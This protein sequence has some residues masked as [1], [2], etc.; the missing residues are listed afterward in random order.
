MIK[1]YF[2]TKFKTVFLFCCLFLFGIQNINAQDVSDQVKAARRARI[3][4][5]EN[6]TEGIEDQVQQGF[7]QKTGISDADFND[8]RKYYSDTLRKDAK[9]LNI[10]LST[11]YNKLTDFQKREYIE[12]METHYVNMYNEFKQ[13]KSEFP[14]SIAEVV[15]QK[16]PKKNPLITCNPACDNVGFENGTLSAWTCGYSDCSSELKPACNNP[17]NGGPTSFSYS[18]PTFSPGVGTQ[19]AL[20]PATGSAAAGDY[21]DSIIALASGNDPVIASGGGTLPMVCPGYNYSCR[22][23]D[24][25]N[26]TSGFL[27]EPNSGV[28]FL[29]QEFTVTPANADFYYNYAVVLENPSHCFHQ[30]PYFKVAMLDMN[31]DTIPHC[32]NYT[33]VAGAT[34]G[35]AWQNIGSDIDGN[36][37][38]W[39]P[40]T[41][42]YISLKKYIGQCVTIIVMTS[43]CGQGGHFGYAYF[44]AQCATLGII[45]S[46]PALCGKPITLTAPN[47]GLS[48][49]WIAPGPGCMTPTAGNTQSIT[50]S[51]PG[52][53]QVIITTVA[54]ASCA[55]TLDTIVASSTGTPPVPFFSS[56][57]VCA[58]NPTQFTNLTTGGTAAT[59]TYLWTFQGGSTSSAVNPTFTFPTAGT[60]TTNLKTTNGGCGGDTTLNVVVTGPPTAGFT[61]PTV[62]QN[63][64]TLFTNT[65]T[66]TATFKWI[67][68]DGTTSTAPSPQ[69]TYA[70]CGTF[71]VILVAGSAPCVDSAKQT[72]TVNPN[73][74]PGFT[75]TP[76]CIGSPTVFND[77]TTVGCGGTQSSWAWSFG[78]PAK[79]TSTSQN[80]SYTYAD[81]GTYSVFFKITT[82][83]GCSDSVIEPVHITGPPVPNFTTTPV[84]LG[85]PTVFTN[86]TKPAPATSSWAFG[87]AAGGT[88]NATNPVYTYTATGTFNVTLT[89]SSGAGCTH[90]TT[91]PIVVNPLPT[92]GFTATTVCQG[93]PT[94][95]TDTSHGGMSW[96]WYYGD[97]AKGTGAGQTP[98][99][100]Y[101]AAGTYNVKEVVTTASGCKDSLTIPV[102]VNP[103]PTATIT[104]PP[105]CLGTPSIF[106]L[107]PTNMGATGTYAWTMGDGVGTST[108]QSPTYTYATNGSYT[109]TVN[110]TSSGSCLG[111]A[112]AVAIVNPI[113]VANFLAPAVCQ[114]QNAVFTSTSTIA[115]VPPTQSIK[116]Y[117]WAFGDGGTSALQNPTHHYKACGTYNVTLTVTSAAGCTHDTTL[118]I[119][120]NPVP[121]PNF[122]A[123][124]VC[125]G[126]VTN[127]TDKSTI[128]CGDSVT[129]WSWNFGDG[130]GASTL[131]NPTHTYGA[132]GTFN[133][134][135]TSTSSN[136]CD[137]SVSIPVTVYPIPV[138]AYTATQPCFGTATVFTDNSTVTGGTITAENWAFGD[139]TNGTGANPSHSYPAAGSYNV[140]LIV[141][142]NHGCVDSTKGV[143]WVNP[144]PVPLFFSD[145]TGCVK[146]CISDTGDH[147]TVAPI[148]GSVVNSW[149]W[150][151][152]DG[153]SDSS[154]TGEFPSHCYTKPGTYTVQLTV[155]TNH[156][157]SATLVKPNYITA[158]PIP[159]ANFTASPNPTD[160]LKP[161][162]VFTDQSQGNPVWWNWTFG[163]RTDSLDST[164]NTTHTYLYT[165][166]FQDTGT[167]L[168]TLWIKN[169]YG[170]EDSITEPIVITPFW[171][172]Y[173]PNA[174]TP[175][176]DGLNDGFIPKAVGVIAFQ[177]W[178]FDRWGQELYHC[179]SLTQPWDGT[180]HTG[181]TS[182]AECQEDTYVWLV[183]FTDIYKNHHRM[184]G[185]V[186]IIK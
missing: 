186:T 85:S 3:E 149:L 104:V 131:Q 88:S 132:S 109:A 49:Q 168:A 121:V 167:Y 182:G 115:N 99:Y 83:G 125:K 86:T 90:D 4:W 172:F 10:Y 158:W 123:T 46:A 11:N 111:T 119:I 129:K 184:V 185:R 89:V 100:T 110:L 72:V 150:N 178:I 93:T 156:G 87:D 8:F 48:Y 120:I 73:P 139:G 58:G 18:A 74:K 24:G 101:A 108:A 118:P 52:K 76:V 56:D 152:G 34:T 40:W 106:T 165:G 54:G 6:T 163:D 181:P 180:V 77:T 164:Q 71:N 41:P 155:G 160:T 69:H 91:L 68:G 92:A 44:D 26:Y 60:Y 130:S 114:D 29:E 157:C 33:A 94:A 175:N 97:P 37:C 142:S 79:G 19:G 84:C 183:E 161:T 55:D 57:T 17:P 78:D 126:F 31:N 25:A 176:N 122:T 169:K 116:T 171:T 21:Q 35:T 102:T 38:A 154:S 9:K 96:K 144:I 7:K 145:T 146:L 137:S 53:Y 134:T 2:T 143:V 170:C 107:T 36:P 151:F 43:D 128:G 13:I 62:C 67:F 27:G 5:M 105:V 103:N 82:S 95:F 127:F 112:T 15:N 47:G 63:S 42:S 148:N 117:A 64:P 65:S 16:A 113:P 20:D 51:C 59:N 177:M 45:T 166:T 30:Q 22:V 81:T 14:S 75:T 28:A 147:S 162:V 124:S 98:T 159:V 80:P 174:F 140:D 173:I 23:G 12:M 1:I 39:L 66:G 61:A 50:I 32:G 136:G 133:V 70:T 138:P 135:L 141:T 153:S 179:T